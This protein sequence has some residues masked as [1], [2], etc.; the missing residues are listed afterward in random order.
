MPKVI[1]L[2]V[3]QPPG[4]IK[5]RVVWITGASTGIGAALAVAAA[6]HGARLVLSARSEDLLNET[7]K[8]CVEAAGG[9]RA[10]EEVL[11][12]PL[13]VARFEDHAPALAKVLEHFGKVSQGQ[14]VNFLA[15]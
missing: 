6:R 9:R 15:F 13:D 10:E 5:G 7:K 11:V 8:K 2:V 4:K 14:V 12:L 3:K 1:N